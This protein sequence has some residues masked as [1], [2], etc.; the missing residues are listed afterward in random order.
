VTHQ[1]SVT[2]AGGALEK[3]LGRREAVGSAAKSAGYRVEGRRVEAREIEDCDF[4]IGVLG[5]GIEKGL[6]L[7]DDEAFKLRGEIWK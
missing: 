1:G 3:V 4:D 5:A 6:L 7:L 2:M